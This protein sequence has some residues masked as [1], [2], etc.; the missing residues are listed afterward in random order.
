MA[1][2]RRAHVELLLLELSVVDEVVDAVSLDFG[3]ELHL[4]FF[5]VLVHVFGFV[6]LRSTETTLMNSAFFSPA[7]FLSFRS[8]L[9]S[10]PPPFCFLTINCR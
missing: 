9:P 6:L 7:L 4:A 1:W 2:V 3:D 10:D 8:E 5:L